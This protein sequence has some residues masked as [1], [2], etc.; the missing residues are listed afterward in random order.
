MF[1]AYQSATVY[2]GASGQLK[3]RAGRKG[4]FRIAA[5]CSKMTRKRKKK[6]KRERKKEEKKNQKSR[7]NSE[8]HAMPRR[9]NYI[10]RHCMY[11][12]P[13][14][15]LSRVRFMLRFCVPLPVLGSL[16]AFK[17][18]EC[19]NSLGVDTYLLRLRVSCLTYA[20]DSPAFRFQRQ[21]SL[22]EDRPAASREGP[23]P[24]WH[25]YQKWSVL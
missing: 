4:L 23:P 25:T 2:A 21:P 7:R 19:H 1:V 10:Y 22:L 8:G 20:V 24:S 5:T 17:D 9:R 16:T 14:P 13:M 11:R 15:Q 6:R 18:I 12:L 3:L